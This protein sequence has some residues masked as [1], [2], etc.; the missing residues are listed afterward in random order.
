MHPADP[1]DEGIV[2][3]EVDE[4]FFEVLLCGVLPC[5]WLNDHY[6]LYPPLVSRLEGADW[7]QK[8]LYDF[9]DEAGLVQRYGSE[10]S[11]H[12]VLCAAIQSEERSFL[13]ESP[14]CESILTE[15]PILN[16]GPVL[17]VTE[18]VDSHL[19]LVK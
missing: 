2:C 16:L 9:F 14:L 1:V 8:D 18:C 19:R 15:L 12:S 7:R 10:L 4:T 3:E 5:G 13:R 11:D 17:V 6:D